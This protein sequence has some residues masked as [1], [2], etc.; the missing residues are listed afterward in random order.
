M[1]R[2]AGMTGLSLGNLDRLG[3]FISTVPGVAAA[4]ED[5]QRKPQTP[6]INPTR[7]VIMAGQ[8]PTCELVKNHE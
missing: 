3:A 5:F 1:E 6:P 8:A 4:V 2:R 7:G